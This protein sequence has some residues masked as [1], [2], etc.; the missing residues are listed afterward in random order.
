[1]NVDA[2]QNA[3]SVLEAPNFSA[4]ET[5][6]VASADSAATS[7]FGNLVMDGLSE[8]NRQLMVQQTDLQQLATGNVQNLHEVMI[9]M[10]EARL[11]FDLMMQVRNRVL[12]SYQDVMKMQV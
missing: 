11:S 3:T 8:V 2:I 4:R 12:E 9:R 10:E 1:M 7:D 5:L 6:S